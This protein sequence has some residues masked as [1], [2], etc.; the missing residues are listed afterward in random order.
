MD[1]EQISI[2]TYYLSSWI[3]SGAMLEGPPMKFYIRVIT[4]MALG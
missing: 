3:P 4:L 2:L 1:L